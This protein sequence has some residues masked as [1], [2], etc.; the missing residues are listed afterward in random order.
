MEELALKNLK[1][2]EAKQDKRSDQLNSLF[3]E[4]KEDDILRHEKEEKMREEN[5]QKA[6]EEHKIK[7]KEN[8]VT[9]SRQSQ[10]LKKTCDKSSKTNPFFV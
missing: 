3:N 6:N 5:L 8:Q 7:M 1:E 4:I 9:I 2:F 10:T